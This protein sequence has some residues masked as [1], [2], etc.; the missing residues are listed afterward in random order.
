MAHNR[1]M[2][3]NN[4]NGE[5]TKAWRFSAMKKWH[6]NWEIRHIKVQFENEDIEFKPLSSDCKVCHEFIGGYIF[7]SMRSKD[8]KQ[9]LDEELFHRLTGGWG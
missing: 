3:V 6:V 4:E 9:A 7:T 8:Q 1:L 2:K 5:P